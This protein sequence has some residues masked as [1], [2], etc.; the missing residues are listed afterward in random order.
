MKT[1]NDVKTGEN[2]GKRRQSTS[3]QREIEGLWHLSGSALRARYEERFNEAPRSRSRISLLRR[4]AWRLQANAEGDLL[5]RA[6]QRALEI[7][8]DAN[9]RVLPP[10]DFALH[11]PTRI[12]ARK[13]TPSQDPR[14]P[15]RGAVLTRQYRGQKVTVTV[16][17]NGFEYAGQTFRS[18]SGIAEK[19]TGTRWNGFV[20]FGLQE[21]HRD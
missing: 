10:R 19:I 20:F 16:L 9:V 2:E 11:A 14:L 4:I 6:R 18:L 3:I 12:A 1:E 7:A 13:R 5:E 21:S 15:E 8:D 17:P